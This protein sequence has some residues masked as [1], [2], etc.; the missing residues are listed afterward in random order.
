MPSAILGE[1][2]DRVK[3]RVPDPTIRNRC[4]NHDNRSD[5]HRPW[6]CPGCDLAV[7]EWNRRHQTGKRAITVGD[8][9]SAHDDKVAHSS[10]SPGEFCR[11]LNW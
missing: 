9:D 11:A 10:G 8:P 6:A 4:Q 3:A 2:T 5:W 1:V 7:P